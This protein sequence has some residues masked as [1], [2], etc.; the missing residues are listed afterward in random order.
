MFDCTR[1]S[2]DVPLA[3]T[4]SLHLGIS[5][6]TPRLYTWLASPQPLLESRPIND[7]MTRDAQRTR[8]SSRALEA[9]GEPPLADISDIPGIPVVLA[10]SVYLTSA[11]GISRR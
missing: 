9:Y 2:C 3:I 7:D 10:F 11:Q 4:A 1:H 8:C 5:G 6:H